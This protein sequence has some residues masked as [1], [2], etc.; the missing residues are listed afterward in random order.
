ME[1]SS[2]LGEMTFVNGLLVNRIVIENSC[3]SMTGIS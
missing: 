2:E 3:L 1:Y